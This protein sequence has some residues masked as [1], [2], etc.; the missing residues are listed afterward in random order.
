M[1]PPSCGYNSVLDHSFCRQPRIF[2]NNYDL[3]TVLK[4]SFILRI[5]NTLND[6]P[7]V[8]EGLFLS[9]KQSNGTLETR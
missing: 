4:T 7:W 5:E 2:L 9:Y 1:Y 8:K 6:W 3:S